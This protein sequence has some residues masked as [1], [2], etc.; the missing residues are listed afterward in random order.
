M[1]VLGGNKVDFERTMTV[2]DRRLGAVTKICMGPWR[3]IGDFTQYVR[4]YR[5]KT[6]DVFTVPEIA[7]QNVRLL[8]DFE[9]DGNDWGPQ[10]GDRPL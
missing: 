10:K 3:G 1:F 2:S 4:Y 7:G 9:G 5:Q 8:G 6:N